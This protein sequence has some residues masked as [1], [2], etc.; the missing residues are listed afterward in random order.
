MSAG[1]LH[2]PAPLLSAQWFRTAGLRPRLDPHAVIE[3][4]VVRGEVWHVLVRADGTRSFRLNAAAWSAVARCDGQ[5][6]VQRL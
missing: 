6:T 1:A 4:S 2:S 3:R 5:L